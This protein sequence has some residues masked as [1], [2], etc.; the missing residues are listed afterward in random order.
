[1][2]GIYCRADLMTVFVNM[3]NFLMNIQVVLDSLKRTS[4]KESF[5]NE[6]TPVMPM[7]H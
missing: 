7:I 3:L 1:M 6:T 5:A 4:L 2:A